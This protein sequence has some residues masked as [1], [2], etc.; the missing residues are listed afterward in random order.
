M[1]NLNKQKIGWKSFIHVS[2][3]TGHVRFFI[4]KYINL[5]FYNDTQGFFQKIP[6]LNLSFRITLQRTT[7]KPNP[8]FWE[9]LIANYFQKIYPISYAKYN[10]H[11]QNN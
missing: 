6:S 8:R 2:L 10:M 4:E 7:Y 9:N 3:Q 11:I 1:R 5:K